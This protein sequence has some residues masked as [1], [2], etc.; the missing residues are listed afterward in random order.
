VT[1]S[2]GGGAS[3]PAASS[4]KIVAQKG[5]LTCPRP[6]G[7]L[8]AGQIG[9]LGLNEPRTQARGALRHYHVTHYG[10]DDFCLYGGWGIRGAYKHN[11]FVLLLTANP[12]YSAH[13]VTDGYTIQAAAKHLKIGKV[14]VLGFND[15]YIAPGTSSNY[16]LKVRNGIVLEIGIANKQ[17][18]TGRANQKKFLSSFKAV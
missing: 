18:T 7:N 3:A 13:G 12:F 11:R 8:T 5:T 14:M 16:V 1:A 6:S 9:P 17:A 10:F 15:W 2:N 4:A